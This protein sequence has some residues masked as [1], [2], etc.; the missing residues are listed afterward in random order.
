MKILLAGGGSG[1]PVSP[2]LA[3]AAELKKLKPRT[4]FLFVGTRR[5]PEREM[6]TGEK[7]KFVSIPAARLRRFWTIKNI[8][9]PFIFIAGLIKSYGIIRKFSPDLIFSAGGFAAVPVSWIGRFLGIKVM[10]HQQDIRIGLANKLIA[11]FAFHITT[12]FEYTSKE[13]YS[14]AGL[15]QSKIT[16]RAEWVGNPVRPALLQS[17]AEA[18]KFF[19]LHESLP[20]LLVVGGATGAA[21]INQLLQAIL[22]Q[23]V[24]SFQVVHQTGAGKPTTF[25]HEN[26][27]SFELIPF[28][29]YAAVLKA[30]HIVIARAG[31]STIAELS[32]LGKSA[33]IIPMPRTHQEDN[34][35][36]LVLTSSAIVLMGEHLKSEILMQAINDLKFKPQLDELLS[37]NIRELMP[38]NA[39][40][41]I[42]KLIIKYVD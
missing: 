28:P 38:T 37:K 21:Q 24:Q 33:I 3:V 16:P 13:F 39:A 5:G 2:V 20:I 4:E 29:E 18:L 17:K 35:K 19:H 7:I 11:P 34:A 9:A 22:P 1:G 14:N 30:A 42:A 36:I 26:Y 27:H 32:A 31:L 12:A 8:A 41:K 25:K 10:I 23:L 6:V 40:E 15:W